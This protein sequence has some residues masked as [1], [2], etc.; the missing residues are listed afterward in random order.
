MAPPRGKTGNARRRRFLVVS[1][2]LFT[3]TSQ[4]ESGEWDHCTYD[5][6]IIDSA[7]DQVGDIPSQAR[8]KG[9]DSPVL[10]CIS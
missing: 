7:K 3:Q 1:A 4:H 2:T 10:R 8:R 6:R 5:I 9:D